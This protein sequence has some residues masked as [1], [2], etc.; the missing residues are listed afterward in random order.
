MT[1]AEC[2]NY[3][4]GSAGVHALCDNFLVVTQVE[5]AL[6]GHGRIDAGKEHSVWVKEHKTV[7][8]HKGRYVADVV[9]DVDAD[10][11]A[12]DFV[13]FGGLVAVAEMR[14]VGEVAVVEHGVVVH[15][16]RRPLRA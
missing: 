11:E 15:K 4:V 8:R 10:A 6:A 9:H 12:A 16:Q 13:D 1:L 7:T 5:N 2:S 3:A 14:D